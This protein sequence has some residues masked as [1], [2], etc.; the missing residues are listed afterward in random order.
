[1]TMVKKHYRKLKNGRTVEIKPHERFRRSSNNSS[2]SPNSPNYGMRFEQFQ[3][4]KFKSE[5][6]LSSTFTPSVQSSKLTDIAGRIQRKF[7][8]PIQTNMEGIHSNSPVISVEP[9]DNSNVSFDFKMFQ[10]AGL[11]DDQYNF[12]TQA[13]VWNKATE[14]ESVKTLKAMKTFNKLKKAIEFAKEYI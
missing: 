6:Q 1:M 10:P 7:G 9:L 2:L 8:I 5:N 14:E 12:K 4:P 3:N 13:V 11:L